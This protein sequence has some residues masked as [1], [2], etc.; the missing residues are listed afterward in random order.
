MLTNAASAPF[1]TAQAVSLAAGGG[2]VSVTTA[3]A[4][5]TLSGAITGTGVLTKAG[6]G[7]LTLSA[8]NTF[9]GGTTINAGTLALAGTS[10]LATNGAV[11]LADAVG[12]TLAVNASN[13]IGSLAGGG[14]TGGTVT[15][16]SGDTLTIGGANTSTTFAGSISGAG[17]LTKTGTGTQTL[18]GSDTY[19][20]ATTVLAGTLALSG[21]TG[22]IA[23]S[24]QVSI[25]TG[26]TL[27]I[28]G[29]ANGGASIKTLADSAA[30]QAG[31]VTL[32]A[33]SLTIAAGSTTFS[34]IIN[35]TGG[36]VIAGGTQTLAGTDNA[37]GPTTIAQGAKLALDGSA[38]A[39]RVLT[40][41]TLDISSAPGSSGVDTVN[42][43]DHYY[44]SFTGSTAAGATGS[45]DT[46]SW[47]TSSYHSA[48]TIELTNAAGIVIDV[49][50]SDMSDN[51]KL[52]GRNSGNALIGTHGVSSGSTQSVV[53]TGSSQ[54]ITAA[55]AAANG[56]SGIFNGGQVNITIG[57]GGIAGGVIASLAGS[58]AVTLG[59]NTL[60]ISNAADTFSGA[61]AGTGGLTLQA[62]S[63]ILTGANTFTGGTTISGGALQIG[64]G[65]TTGS[66]AGNVVDNATLILDPSGAGGT[67]AGNVSGAG[68]VSKIGTATETL[69]GTLTNAAINAGTGTPAGLLQFNGTSGLTS[70]I[71]VNGARIQALTAG[72]FGTGTIN[73]I[74]PTIEYSATGT[75]ANPIVLDSASTSDP[76]ELLADSGV[77]VTLTG[78]ITQSTAN[79]GLTNQPLLVDG[80]GTIALAAASSYTGGTTL[81]GGTLELAS[82]NASGN[83]AAGSATP[84]KV[85]FSGA[86]A[87]L[88]L[89]AAALAGGGTY[90]GA[91][92]GFAL[93]DTLDLR[94]LT[95]ARDDLATLN[96]STL[97]VGDATTKATLTAFSDASGQNPYFVTSADGH[98]GTDVTL[99][100]QPAAPTMVVVNPSPATYGQALTITGDGDG[101]GDTIRVYA[102]QANAPAGTTPTL[103]GA[104]TINGA[105]PYAFTATTPAGAVPDGSFVVTTTDASAGGTTPSAMSAP[106]QVVVAAN[107]PTNLAQTNMP[108]NGGVISVSG[109]TA[110]A[111]G[112]GVEIYA[113]AMAPGA[114]AVDLGAATVTAGSNGAA[115]RFTFTSTQGFADGDYTITATDTSRDGTQSASA[116]TVAAVAAT[117]P[118][119]LRQTNAP[120]NGGGAEITGNGD[121][122]G[123]TITVYDSTTTFTAATQV[124]TMTEGANGAFDITTGGLGDGRHTLTVRNT[125]ADGTQHADATVVATVLPTSPTVAEANRPV[126]YGVIEFTGTG[127]SGDTL[128]VTIGGAAAAVTNTNGGGAGTVG[129]DGTYDVTTA[130]SYSDGS[131]PVSVTQTDAAALTG[132]AATATAYVYPAP[133]VIDTVVQGTDTPASGSTLVVSGT[134]DSAGDTIEIFETP[135]AGGPAT[136]IG[137]GTVDNNGHFSVITTTPVR[138]GSYAVTATDVDATN[139]SS[140]MSQPVAATAVPPAPSSLMQDGTATTPSAGCTA[141]IAIAGTADNG[142]TVDLYDTDNGGHVLAGTANVSSSG[143]FDITTSAGYGEGKHSFAATQTS[144][145]GSTTSLVSATVTASVAPAAP[146]ALA[147]KVAA[148]YDQADHLG[149]AVEITGS[150]DVAGDTIAL[151]A[152]GGTAVVGT[153][154]V[155]A[156]GT[157]DIVTSVLYADGND[158]F[159]ATDTSADGVVGATSAPASATVSAPAPGGVAQVGTAANGGTIEVGGIGDATGDTITVYAATNGGA[160]QAIG[161][162]TVAGGGRFDF[163][164]TS[165]FADGTYAVTAADTSVDTKQASAMSA[166]ASVVVTSTAPAGLR[167]VNAPSNGQQIEISGSGDVAG[168][169]ITI[170]D[171]STL[172]GAATA[173]AGG[174]FDATTT[175]TGGFTDGT[176]VLT[177]RNTSADGTQHADATIGATVAA[178]APSGLRQVG[179]PTNGQAIEVVGA[180]TDAVGD[181]ITLSAAMNGGAAAVIGTTTVVAGAN[182]ANTFDYTSTQG[183]ADGRYSVAAT[184]TSLDGTQ[185]SAA[186]APVTVDVKPSAPA[187]TGESNHPGN[188]GMIEVTGTAEA[189]TTLTLYNNGGTTAV[190]TGTA[191]ANGTFDIVESVRLAVGKYGVTATATDAGGEVS[192]MSAPFAASIYPAR[193]AITS[194]TVGTDMPMA[195]TT[196]EVKG[197]GDKAGDAIGVYANG[198]TTAL[199][200]G[201]VANNG[202]FDI[203]VAAL[204]DGTYTLTA[205]DTDAPSGVASSPSQPATAKLTPLAPT[206]LMQSGTTIAG[207]SVTITGNGDAGDTVALYANGDT[208]TVVGTG[209]VKADGTFSVTTTT[210]Y[211]KGTDTFSATETSADKTLT[212]GFGSAVTANVYGL[213]STVAETDTVVSGNTVT[214]T[215][216]TGA[217]KGDADPNGGTLRITQVSY[218]TGPDAVVDPVAA[219]STASAGATVIAGTYGSLAI[220]ADG[221]YGYSANNGLAIVTV[222]DGSPITD[223]FG[224]VVTESEGPSSPSSLAITTTLASGGTE[225]VDDATGTA[226]FSIGATTLS[227]TNDRAT[228]Y[229]GTIQDGSSGNKGGKVVIAGSASLTL[230][231]TSTFTGGTTIAGG[232]LVEQNTGAALS[233]GPIA[234]ASGATLDLAADGTGAGSTGSGHDILLEGTTLSGAGRLEKTGAG[235]VALGGQGMVGI[236]LARGGLIDVEA[237]TLD[238][239]AYDQASY[240]GNQGGLNIASG[241][242]FDGV[243][244]TIAVGGLDG[245]GTLQGGYEG[246]GGTTIG[247][248]TVA[249]QV[250]TFSGV[251]RDR[252]TDAGMASR[253]ALTK[254]GAGTQVLTGTSTYSGGTTIAGGTLE[255]GDGV[256]TGSI[257][258]VVKNGGTLAFDEA[259]A[260]P[261]SFVGTISDNGSTV[262]AVIQVGGTT[263]LTGA[264][265]FTGGTTIA[266]G[267]LVEQNTGAA[268]SSGP[269][270]IASGATLDLAAD[271]T[272]A[273]STGS[274]HDILLEGTTLSGAGRLEKT[275]AGLVALGGQGMVGIA[276]ARGGLIDVEAGTLDG[277]AYNQASYAG[278]QGGLNIASGATFDGVEGTIA[279]GGLDGAGTLQGGYEG[280]GSTTIG[281]GTVAGQVDTF[282]GVI[283]DR[284]T[285][286][287]MASR[288]ALTKSGAGTQ[289]LTG[290]DTFTGGTTIAGG[291]LVEQNTGAALSSGPIAIASG[292]TLDLAADGTGA[293]S[294]G[295]GHDILLE[296]TT[297][298]G[299][300]RLEK[301]G[302]GLVALGGQGMVGIALARGGLIDVE[303][304][305]LDGSAYDQASYAGNQGGLNIASGATFD[306][307]E[308]TIVVGGLDG[309]G[310]LQGGYE[311]LGGTTIGAGTVAGQ[312][313]TFSGVIRDRGT[314][315]G[316]ASRLALTKSGAGTQVLTGTSTY[317]GGTTIAGGTLELGGLGAAGS[318][319]ITFAGA[320]TLEIDAAAETMTSATS[321]DFANL[322]DGATSTSQVIDLTS[323][324][325]HQGTTT[326]SLF[327]GTLTV[328]NG[329]SDPGTDSVTLR[330]T[331]A[332]G[333]QFATASDGRGGTL[334]YDPPATATLDTSW[335]SAAMADF[336]GGGVAAA[337]VPAHDPYGAA[338]LVASLDAATPHVHGPGHVG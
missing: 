190:G 34:G 283:R 181:T 336:G 213:P 92:S 175:R 231:G 58:G 29:L 262:G 180:T 225:T 209:T 333:K 206:N 282:S 133:P 68:T 140:A 246:L 62:G 313:D 57:D 228:T 288:L 259:A 28:T 280:L 204:A 220:G 153:G 265:T 165:P 89:D 47:Q 268:L 83:A 250:D 124:G 104:T 2:T 126:N 37:T 101:T 151:Y 39:T 171:G 312:V 143:T 292:A 234:I 166:V 286:A 216:A 139:V 252:G 38:S 74:D 198:G 196:I 99:Q 185:I 5:D 182:G 169:A 9:T 115:N 85:A 254:S 179:T 335:L 214:Q 60:T 111:A 102:T 150:G 210:T 33:E 44:S 192:A 191:T 316:M 42:T 264:D 224:D 64:D 251:I 197:T 125:S 308:G 187:V 207:G 26:A 334:V 105:S 135:G 275:G 319:R 322:I 172:V 266:G 86:A 285:D 238:G 145:D 317:S 53:V 27:S 183:F 300:G 267:A 112:D 221:S 54:N 291:T 103:L 88:Q 59:A 116:T 8:A 22:A 284:G 227:L 81:S 270:A 80:A 95:Y 242:T 255:L 311:G 152:N 309:A 218:G 76:T 299:A 25:A 281:A 163:R 122:P 294:T 314:D 203:T 164:S 302:A 241:A 331:N 229:G 320:A 4:N 219:G 36:L 46:L 222:A 337:A 110:D 41:G 90:A 159:A 161:T 16:A 128:N 129:A 329:T 147:Q 24:G 248:G 240:A 132:A 211:P 18:S 301:T 189:G 73:A 107:A 332:N 244:G 20:G 247:A 245:A 134:G 93:G 295:S 10:A 118:T 114:T 304:G 158:T 315:A 243:E 202:S 6:A 123:D 184:D 324:A 174:A 233:S 162:T 168:D 298:S 226:T 217:L 21:T 235:L 94:G 256:T 56:G 253:L 330:V 230:T 173:G 127:E 167:E 307:V 156:G 177:V 274:G 239:S 72:A 277:S 70:T 305:T 138:D 15:I 50:T 155:T 14:T 100:T 236:A 293:G 178:T 205:T 45:N 3:A 149:V 1:S 17:V 23:S 69:T 261:L 201:S 136:R 170:Y 257:T 141:T 71:N 328:S 55:I 208:T 82:A 318:G 232:A 130:G 51:L 193:P 237:G 87:T 272:G 75:Y 84:G 40:N 269:I 263:T 154:T 48:Y 117:A 276:L 327:N 258:G 65:T 279:V 199:A 79:G 157:F 97:T 289:V 287:G 35:G 296:G 19:T 32:G 195:G 325:F 131:Y 223:G 11:A 13:T 91:I 215:T 273:G 96:G 67:F 78:G 142:D 260:T 278:N 61:V 66:L 303:A 7:A 144:A 31:T 146:T 271:G 119:N 109:A 148:T 137:S 106:V 200:T 160:A 77:M 249:S 30:G 306:G 188:N 176:H 326:A 310:T 113:T 321:A 63:E 297:L 120:V 49:V 194:A 212:S 290:A 121:R 186:S 43:T 108:V 98:G 323:L 338:G 52:Y 12:A